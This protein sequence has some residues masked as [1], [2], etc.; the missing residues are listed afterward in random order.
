MIHQ[1]RS[2]A[3]G[4]ASD[5]AI[6]A[7]E[8]LRNKDSLNRELAAMCNQPVEKVAKDSDR[9]FFMGAEDAKVHGI[10]RRREK[11]RGGARG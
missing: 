5:I 9:D 8:V 1:P 10:K 2:G 6:E 7:R 11:G 3:Q 4:Q